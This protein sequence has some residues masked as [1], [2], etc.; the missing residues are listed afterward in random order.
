MAVELENLYADLDEKYEVTLRTSSCFQ[1]MI[2]WIHMV[3]DTDFAPFLHGDE[4]VFN[5]GLNYVSEEW[6]KNFIKVLNQKHSGGTHH[7]T[8]GRTGY[9]SGYY[10]ILQRD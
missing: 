10:Y 2:G 9:I 8:A 7:C 4:L 6:L 3:E 5:S 1:K